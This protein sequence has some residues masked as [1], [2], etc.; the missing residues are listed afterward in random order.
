MKHAISLPYNTTRLYPSKRP[1]VNACASDTATPRQLVCRPVCQA[2]QRRYRRFSTSPDCHGSRRAS[3]VMYSLQHCVNLSRRACRYFVQVL[4]LGALVCAHVVPPDHASEGSVDRPPAGGYDTRA[5]DR[6]YD[7]NSL[8]K[9]NL[10]PTPP[11]NHLT[12]NNEVPTSASVITEMPGVEVPPEKKPVER[13]P[14]ISVSFH[15]VETPFIIGL[16]IFCA[17]LAKIGEF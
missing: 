2:S 6:A 11:A 17:S 9:G 5:Y 14:V 15:R 10:I 13:Y 16:W 7:I 3:H 12:K 4:C 1:L 8:A